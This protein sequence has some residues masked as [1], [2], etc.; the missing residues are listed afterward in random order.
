MLPK[1]KDR[2]A[3]QTDGVGWTDLFQGFVSVEARWPSLKCI[4]ALLV[5]RRSVEIGIQSW[6]GFECRLEPVGFFD[7]NGNVMVSGCAFA[8]M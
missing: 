3:N 1:P 6:F 8:Q 5:P 7:C 4:R 2:V